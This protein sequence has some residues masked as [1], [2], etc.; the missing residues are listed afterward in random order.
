M[1]RTVRGIL[2]SKPQDVWAVRSDDTVFDALVVMAEHNI[3][4][5]PVVEESRVIGIFSER[6]YA[7]RVVLH[8]RVS[9]DTK[10]GEVMTGTVQTVHPE[11]TVD[12]CMALMT[13]GRFR[14]LPVIDESASLI[15]IISIG[16]VVRTVIESQQSL[17]GDLERYIQA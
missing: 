1:Q 15:G 10:I 7:R 8:D 6:D 5:V 11:D 12:R 17:I 14:H 9:R 3:G 2:D 16:D 4:A 13:A